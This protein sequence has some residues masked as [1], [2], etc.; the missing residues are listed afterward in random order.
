MQLMVTDSTR[1]NLLKA[2]LGCAA[3]PVLPFGCASN[4]SDQVTD[5]SPKLIGCALNGRDRFSAVVADQFGQP[6]SQLPIP[7]RG[8]GV[9][10]SPKQNHAVVF[11]RR[12]GISVRRCKIF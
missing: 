1:R 12:P 11:A 8:H 10:I 9:A 2:A 7:E 5:G 6:I 3:V 4:Q